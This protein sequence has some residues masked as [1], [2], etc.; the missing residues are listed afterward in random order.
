L[1][2]SS[3]LPHNAPTLVGWLYHADQP[4]LDQ[5]AYVAHVLPVYAKLRCAPGDHGEDTNVGSMVLGA[6]S[7][8]ASLPT[9]SRRDRLLATPTALIVSIVNNVSMLNLVIWRRC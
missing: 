5:T 1:N 2:H 4:R 9:P 3:D 7:E 6:V 8:S